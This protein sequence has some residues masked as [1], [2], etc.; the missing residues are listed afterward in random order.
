MT[1]SPGAKL[2]RVPPGLHPGT[3]QRIAAQ[4]LQGPEGRRGGAALDQ[5]GVGEDGGV[6]VA[7]RPP[8]RA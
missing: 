5:Q 4:G 7:L 3:V 1:A 6:R 2:A 8:L